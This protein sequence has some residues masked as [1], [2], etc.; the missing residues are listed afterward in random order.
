MK[1]IVSALLVVFCAVGVMGQAS[2]L[3]WYTTGSG[4]VGP[5]G[6]MIPGSTDSSLGALVQVIK[7]SQTAPD[8]VPWESDGIAGTDVLCT[9]SYAGK[10]GVGDG[11]VS[12]FAD[13]TV[14]GIGLSD[15]V[16]VRVWSEPTANA[17]NGWMPS[18]QFYA[19][20][21]GTGAYYYDYA[22]TTVSTLPTA[23]GFYNY[24]LGD[25]GQNDW[26]FVAIPEPTTVGLAALGLIAMLV[27]KIRK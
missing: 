7:N 26:T 9:W 6:A 3:N 24:E 15:D 2:Y 22:L 14:L 10:G 27:R 4:L 18:P 19:S 12:D 25:I 23:A 8:V 20:E 17:A 1:L 13:F 16:F 5:D 11:Q 21:G